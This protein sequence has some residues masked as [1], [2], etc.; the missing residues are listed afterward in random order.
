[1]A[2]SDPGANAPSR[3]NTKVSKLAP[4]SGATR[5]VFAAGG[6][7]QLGDA[8]LALWDTA[9]WRSQ[10]LPLQSPKGLGR[11]SDGALLVL[12]APATFHGELR[13]R[14]LPTLT[15]EPQEY[16]GFASAAP[17]LPSFVLQG[18]DKDSFVLVFF[19][20]GGCVTRVRLEAGGRLSARGVHA[21]PG[22]DGEAAAT[23]EG[24]A[25]I[26]PWSGALRR[27]GVDAT[28]GEIPLPDG[29]AAPRHLVAGPPGQV[30]LST[31]DGRLALLA[32]GSKAPVVWQAQTGGGVFHLAAHGSTAAA[33]LVDPEAPRDRQTWQLAVF[34]ASSGP[35]WRQPL[36]APSLPSQTFVALSDKLV[37]VGG[38]EALAAW[39][40]KTGVSARG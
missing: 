4:Q 36:A 15:A 7:A 11:L 21:L 12:D 22:V 28:V 33:L 37:V 39:D 5:L 40:S 6:L 23:L 34:E 9:T 29:L 14:R 3:P 30:W 18:E 1:M 20:S 25:A 13:A 17:F 16:R 26:Y 35:L 38:P 10:S 24:G 27:V 8:A 2:I 32:P 19:G 31:Q